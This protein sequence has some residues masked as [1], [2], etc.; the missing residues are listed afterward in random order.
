MRWTPGVRRLLGVG[1]SPVPVD[2]QMIGTIRSRLSLEGVVR[3]GVPFARGDRV[4]IV[5]GPMAGL[6]GILERP[7]S[8]ANRVRILLEIL[9]VLVE[10][11]WRLLEAD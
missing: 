11:D 2:E 5:E 9:H 4:R 1:D 3:V 7:T 6:C 8:R 10:L